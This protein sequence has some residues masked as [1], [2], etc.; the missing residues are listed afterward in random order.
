MGLDDLGCGSVI[1]RVLIRGG[2]RLENQSEELWGWK[3]RLERCHC[4]LW[5][6]RKGPPPRR[7]GTPEAGDETRK[8]FSPRTSRRSAAQ[9]TLAVA[10]PCDLW[11]LTQG[12]PVSVAPCEMEIKIAHGAQRC[13]RVLLGLRVCHTV[14][15]WCR[16]SGCA[17]RSLAS[18]VPSAPFRSGETPPSLMRKLRLREVLCHPRLHSLA[19]PGLDLSSGWSPHKP[20]LL[21]PL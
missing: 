21:P 15:I 12:L 3:Q 11:E 19:V 4:W 5:R 13:G 17:L 20:R 9:L 7:A 6:R 10:Q 2:G 18:C 16:H 8:Q 1:T 14:Y